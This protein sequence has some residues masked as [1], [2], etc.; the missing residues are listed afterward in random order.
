M[1]INTY[2][3]Q[4]IIAIMQTASQFYLKNHNG[5]HFI[6]KFIPALHASAKTR[7]SYEQTG[8][9]IPPFLIASIASQCN[10]H[11]TGCYA[12]AGG[13]CDITMTEP[14]MS[15]EHWNKIFHEASDLGISFI[16]LAGGEPLLC[17]EIVEMAANFTNIAFPVFTNGTLIDDEYN[18]LFD[19]HRNIIPVLSIEGSSKETDY[20][21]GSGVSEKIERVMKE[22]KL[23]NI[24]FG[25]SITVM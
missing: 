2:M 23:K 13:I 10:L 21:R 24:L 1:D 18:K 15:M 7:N 14:E 16:L 6:T 22:L 5:R 9:H 17:R 3:E 11:C 25:T 20:R 19:Q 12:R 8:V 4:G